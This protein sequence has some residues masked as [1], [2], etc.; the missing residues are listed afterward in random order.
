MTDEEIRRNIREQKLRK[1][2]NRRIVIICI[3]L[4]L[5]IVDGVFVGK[6]IGNRI[7]ENEAV[8]ITRVA[9]DVPIVNTAMEQ[10]GNKGGKKFW[11]WYGFNSHVAWCACFASWCESQTGLIADGKA[12]KFAQVGYGVDF[13][14]SKGHWINGGDMPQAGDLIFFDWEPDD[15]LDHVGIVTGIVDDKVY[16]IEGNS[17]DRCRQKRYNLD[18]ECIYGYGRF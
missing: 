4:V 14:K 2:R 7:Y 11:S 6:T 17:S 5:A 10:I 18:D 13:F 1:R 12:I 9:E 16:T 15:L 3:A 8:N